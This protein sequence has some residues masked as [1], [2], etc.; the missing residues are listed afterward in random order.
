GIALLPTFAAAEPIRTGAL[1]RVLPDCAAP[2]LGIYAV[3]ASRKQMPL[4]MR[5]MIDFL[6]E[7]FG[8]TPAWDA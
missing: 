6:A 1:V 8:D 3:Y 7:R 2:E 4:A 5:T